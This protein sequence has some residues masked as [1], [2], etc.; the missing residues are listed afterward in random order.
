M[1]TFSLAKRLTVTLMM[2]VMAAWLLSGCQPA[3]Q[4]LSE[5]EIEANNRGVGLMGQYRNEDARQ[6]FAELLAARPDWVDVEV[7]LAIA[8]LNRQR[9]NDELVA[10]DI[11]ERV[12]EDHPDHQRARYIAG[13]MR[14]YIG[15]NE[16]ALAHFQTLRE[17]VPDDAHLAYFTAQTLA[18]LGQAEAAL[19]LYE[20]AIELDPYLRSSYYGAALILRQLGE[21]EAAR[22]QLATYQ[23]FANNP[24]AQLAEF[25]YTRKGPLAEAQAVSLD[26]MPELAGRPAGELFAEPVQLGSLGM[27]SSAVTVTTADLSGDGLQDL[28]ITGGVGHGNQLWQQTAEGFRPSPHPLN[29]I[30]D[31][32]AVAWGD[33]DNSGQL[34]AYLCREGANSLRSAALGWAPM[35]GSAD[36]ADATP[37][38]DVALFDADHDGDLDI[39]VA[40]RGHNELFN[41]NLNGSFRRLSHE[42]EPL[43]A[44]EAVASRQVLPVDLDGDRILDLVVLNAAPP[45]QVLHNDRLWRYQPASGFDRFVESPLVA[46]VAADPAATGQQRLITADEAGQL[47]IWQPDASGDW[48]AE[49]LLQLPAPVTSLLAIDLDGNGR[50]DLLVQHA[51]GVGVWGF[52]NQSDD[53]ID[54]LASTLEPRFAFDQPVLAMA[55]ILIDATAGPSLA[56]VIE[57]PDDAPPTLWLWPPGEGR[58]PFVSV[59][60]SGMTDA[61]EGMRSNASGLGTRVVARVGQR[62]SLVDQLD[63]HSAVGQSL[64]PIAL[65]LGDG[66]R[67]DF[68]KLFWTDGVLQTELSLA[69]GPVHR[70]SELQRQLASCPVLFA[71]NGERFDFVSDL[72]GV[73]GI[74]FFQEPGVYAEPRPWE[75]FIFPEGTIMPREGRYE[76]KISEPMEEI[77][78]IDTASLHIHDLPPGWGVTLNERMYTGSG[79]VPDGS[80]VFYPLSSIRRPVRAINDRGEDVTA[81]ILSQDHVAAD[82]GPRDR[83]FLGRLAEDHVLT[84]EFDEVINPPGSNPVM[85]AYGWVEYPYSQTGFAAWQAGADYR[86][87]S[88]YAYAAGEWQSVHQQFGY[89]AGMP[90]EMSMALEALPAETTALRLVGN[91]EVYWDLIAVVDAQPAPAEAR[92]WQQPIVEARMAKTGFARRDTMAQ[93]LPYYDY[94]DRSPFWD[95]LYPKGYYTSLGPVEP[96]VVEANNA[97]AIVGPGEELHLEFDA[98]SPLTDEGWQRRVV[99]EVRGFAKDMDLYTLDGETVGPLPYTEGVDSSQRD[100]LHARYLKRFQGGF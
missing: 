67:V 25:R 26:P 99:L 18:Q 73:G 2:A 1:L 43:L 86:P 22:E 60:V 90:R 52:D 39:F 41:N 58:Y 12:L 17:T 100:A 65:G 95:T 15:Q 77:A 66:E 19:E 62:W 92:H 9:E 23:R 40:N 96:L 4:A 56:V 78:Y 32:M 38:F 21:P 42:A 68:L 47:Q 49:T 75:F 20:Q 27:H 59:Q 33:V 11:V 61:G 93:Q 8:T 76:L 24:R 10:L 63:P 46:V 34:E 70:I 89:P 57:E 87:P 29:A 94:N 91:W 74:G 13:L 71:W 79:P 97:F 36:V 84:L 64:Q 31:V 50:Q 37:C 48:L 69:P 85:L 14:F 5:T 81:A 82:P 88:L 51:E 35:A 53:Q 80:P 45:H 83:R 16:P 72:L 44:G 54:D 7:N 98:P 6:V 3:S 28:F 30:E 55:P